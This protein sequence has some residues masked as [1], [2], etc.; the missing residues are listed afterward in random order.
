METSLRAEWA[1]LFTLLF[2][3]KDQQGPFLGTFPA[4][5]SPSL[6]IRALESGIEL[7]ESGNPESKFL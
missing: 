4:R 1:T 6:H 3:F 7:K 5:G 2:Y